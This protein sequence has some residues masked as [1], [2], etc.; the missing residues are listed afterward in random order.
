MGTIWSQTYCSEGRP[1]CERQGVYSDPCPSSWA[2]RLASGVTELFLGPPIPSGAQMTRGHGCQCASGCF[3]FQPWNLLVRDNNNTPPMVYYKVVIHHALFMTLS[4]FRR[5][6]DV[7]IQL[8]GL[9]PGPA[10]SCS[11]S[12]VRCLVRCSFYDVPR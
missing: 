8:K 2:T 1:S 12:G 9:L 3:L 4:I 7:M 5:L 6:L 11:E 10:H